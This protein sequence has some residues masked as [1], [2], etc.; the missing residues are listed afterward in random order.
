MKWLEKIYFYLHGRYG[1]I[2]GFSKFLVLLAILLLA[3]SNLLSTRLA[4]YLGLALLAYA[5]LRP[6]SK[7]TANRRKEEAIYQDVKGQVKSFGRKL[8]AFFNS[9]KKRAQS[10]QTEPIRPNDK[11]VI[12]CPK[13]QQKLRV[14]EG[15]KL[16]I[17][18]PKCGTVFTSHS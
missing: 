11:T 13:C 8:Q 9:G 7:E 15:K 14:D 10:S 3:L 18:C 16:R 2:D 12:I 5:S 1:R 6:L 4:F 17:T